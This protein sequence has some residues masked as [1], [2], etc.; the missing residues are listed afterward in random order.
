MHR[1][2]GSTGIVVLNEERGFTSLCQGNGDMIV[3]A[4]NRERAFYL[5]TTTFDGV[6]ILGTVTLMTTYLTG[7]LDVTGLALSG[8]NLAICADGKIYVQMERFM[9][10]FHLRE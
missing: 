8:D 10:T 9:Y 4:S 1:K 2:R 7:W 3:A 5:I 6:G